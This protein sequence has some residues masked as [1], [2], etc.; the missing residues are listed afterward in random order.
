MNISYPAVIHH[1]DNA[2]WIEFPDLE[3]CHT[4]ADTLEDI[5]AEAKEALSAYCSVIVEDNKLLPQA[6]DLSSIEHDAND[7]IAL[8]EA[9]ITDKQ[10][11]V[12]KTLTIPAWLNTAAEQH[13][14]NFSQVL[15]EALV[16]RLNIHP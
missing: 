2:Y 14:I 11:S 16:E 3:G 12:K 6:S 10:R 5:F 4:F 7:I 13:R 8:I 1:E 15:Q 9:P